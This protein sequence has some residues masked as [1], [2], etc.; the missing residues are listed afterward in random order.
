M[1][2]SMLDMAYIVAADIQTHTRPL[3]SGSSNN[4]S[5][6]TLEIIMQYKQNCLMF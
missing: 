2:V 4:P 6:H 3:D 5:P 1:Y